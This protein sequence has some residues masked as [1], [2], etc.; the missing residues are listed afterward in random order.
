LTLGDE[1]EKERKVTNM[2]EP[3]TEGM[4]APDFSLPSDQEGPLGLSDMK[5]EKVV[6]YF[7]PKDNT[8]G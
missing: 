4:M 7:Y 6:L 5:G 8:S 1:S 3:L 2:K